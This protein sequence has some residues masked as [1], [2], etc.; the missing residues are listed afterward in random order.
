M[1]RLFGGTVHSA[2]VHAATAYDRKESSKKGYNHYALAIYL[3]RIQDIEKDIAAG[4]PLRAAL[5]AGFTGR[6]LD[7]LLVA[8]GE[9]KF[10]KEE[11]QRQDYVYHGG[12]P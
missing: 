11:M 1:T 7:C 3:G 2:L 8:V 4:E 6:L 10:T 5:L 9:P 12:R